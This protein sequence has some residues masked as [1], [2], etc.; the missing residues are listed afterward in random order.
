MRTALTP[1]EHLASLLA[2]AVR[3]GGLAMPP[4]DDID[5][6]IE[7][8]QGQLQAGGT[9][10]VAADL[11]HDAVQRFWRTP[12]LETLKD[13]RLVAFGLG[14]PAGPG[15]GCILDDRQRLDAA[16]QGVDQWLHDAR[17]YR[18]GYQ[19]LVWSYFHFDVDAEGVCPAT[20]QNWQRLR[21]YLSQRAPRTV[22]PASNPDWVKTVIFH[23]HLFGE[24]P[25]ERHAGDLLRGDRAEVDLIC[26]RLGIHGSSWFLRRL[27]QAQVAAAVKLDHDEFRAL[28]PRLIDMLSGARALRDDGLACLLER[29]HR[30]PQSPLHEGLRDA[31]AD[32][33]GSPW[34]PANELRWSGVREVVR[35]TVSEWLKADLI[36]R[37]FA[38]PNDGLGP[39]R[40]A[41]WKRYVKSIRKIEFAF[42]GSAV[43]A[44]QSGAKLG[45]DRLIGRC[46]GV[47][48][49][50]PADRALMLTLGRAVVVEFGD[51]AVPLHGYDLRH[52]EP[53][54]SGRPLALA[55]D[56]ENSLRSHRRSLLL[57]HQDG[58]QGW[59]QWEQMFEAALSDQFGIRPGT[60][61]SADPLAC[62]DLS[63]PTAGLDLGPSEPAGRL[64]GFPRQTASSGE[65]VYWLT[66]EAASV[67]YS[68]A[69]LEV[70]ARVHALRID[71][72]TTRTGRLW[73]RCDEADQR[74]ARVLRCWG[75]EHVS[76]EGWRR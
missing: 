38:D 18:R 53:F 5:A 44:S 71:D 3:L 21:D 51:A 7:A 42:G 22:A 56:A 33:W 36:D 23:R 35:N 74:I 75:F 11:Q 60:V 25:C 17:W 58:L 67:P 70:L 64:D 34:L 10:L 19:G 2:P 6:V 73:V 41:F 76:G 57:P 15:G 31:A 61:P 1:V 32:W 52:A 54:V 47:S 14:L 72:E 30:V 27:V 8:L 4:A 49:G 43:Q 68:R 40:A 48:D 46:A 12:R 59:R 66:A 39:R 24:A 13:A 9:R 65:D 26:E 69:D 63:D 55:A 28:L 16:L 29:Q 45:P 20:R 37:F 62:V 50:S